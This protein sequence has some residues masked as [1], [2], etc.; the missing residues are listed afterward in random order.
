MNPVDN[1]SDDKKFTDQ[2]DGP[3]EASENL[4]EEA[5]DEEYSESIESW[6]LFQ[7]NIRRAMNIDKDDEKESNEIAKKTQIEQTHFLPD[8]KRNNLFFKPP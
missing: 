5:V 6:K 4:E 1:P 8:Y 3:P 2:I 7:K